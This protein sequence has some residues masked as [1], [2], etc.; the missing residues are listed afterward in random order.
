MKSIIRG[1]ILLLLLPIFTFT[2]CE[3][4]I[5][6]GTKVNT[7]K[8]I[9]RN[10]GDDNQPGAFLSG[11]DNRIWLEVEQEY[12]IAKV[13]MEVEYINKETGQTERKTIDAYYDEEKKQ[14][15][16]DLDTS[17]MEDGAIKAWI[18]AIDIDGNKTTTTDIIYFVKNLP[19]QIKLT[20]PSVGDNDFDNDIFLGNLKDAD[21]LY[22]G[23]E[24]MG[25]ATDNYGI[26]EG[27]PKIMIW[28]DNHPDV[29]GDGL[30]IML[31]D[32]T[33]LNGRYGTW[34]S[35]VVQNDKNGLTVKKFSWPMVNLAAD[36]AAPGG[37][38]LPQGDEL[39]INLSPAVKYRFRIMTKD[40]FGNINY[41]PNRTDNKRGPGGEAINP[42]DIPRK[43][44]EISYIAADIPIIQITDCPQYY[45][46]AKD[47]KIDFLISSANPMHDTEPIY[48]YIK[49]QTDETQQIV[50]GPYYRL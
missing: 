28:P 42:A 15:Y 46:A 18:T 32:G 31:P 8:P 12:G 20:M 47:F 13:F 38:R 39:R 34:R 21:P 10:A 19:P 25:L 36:P 50:G 4:P 35:L 14:W 26:E 11:D 41:Y 45:N 30:P 48:A 33:P 40:L 16:V 17:N 9:I 5:G 22:L 29:D 1:V 6:L 24:M 2:T 43:Y 49:N 7:E 23:F 27:Y 44:V 3:S 37:Y